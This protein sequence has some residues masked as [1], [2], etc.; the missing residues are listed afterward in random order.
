MLA[1]ALALAAL[2]WLALII[3]TPLAPSSIATLMYAAGAVI[4]HQL[5]ER[6]FH[7]AGFQLPVCARC[8]GIYAGATAAASIHVLGVFV[9]DSARWRLLSPATAR[10]V[11]LLSALPTLVTV[12]L[13]RTD[14]W[15]GSNI[16][17]ATAGVVLG[18]GGALVVM[19]AATLHYSECLRRRPI[20]PSQI[21]PH[22]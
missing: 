13:E 5:P 20:E 4:C 8:L 2:A 15:G 16:V 21:P 11:F 3:I 14:V 10:R 19:S 18:I 6:S 7:L 12:A 22:I 9:T 1:P 17:R